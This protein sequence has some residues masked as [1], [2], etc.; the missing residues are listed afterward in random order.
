MIKE[1]PVHTTTVNCFS[2]ESEVYAIK[3]EDFCRFVM[4]TDMETWQMVEKN[5]LQ[6]EMNIL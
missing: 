1:L 4:Q 3:C 2:S 5:A 6:K